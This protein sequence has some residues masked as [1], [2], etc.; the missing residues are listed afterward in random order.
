MTVTTVPKLLIL[1][2]KIIKKKKKIEDLRY[3][4]NNC[5]AELR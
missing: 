4:I 3:L 5:L 1:N 2:Q